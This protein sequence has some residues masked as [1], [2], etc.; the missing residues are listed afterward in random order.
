VAGESRD[1]LEIMAGADGCQRGAAAAAAELD[2]AEA[3]R[4]LEWAR[5]A[6]KLAR[7]ADRTWPNSLVPR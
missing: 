2:I 5:R 4:R 3:G 1:N 7:L 6:N